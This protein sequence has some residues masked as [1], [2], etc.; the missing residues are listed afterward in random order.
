[1]SSMPRPIRQAAAIPVRAGRVCLVRSRS[2]D[3]WVIP[4]G[5]IEPGHMAG[6]TALRE[7]WEEAG[8]VGRLCPEPVGTY[9]Y[10]KYGRTYQVA[11]YLMHVTRVL[12]D[13]PE[14]SWRTRLWVSAERA[15][16]RLSNRGLRN[17]LWRVA[18][19]ELMGLPAR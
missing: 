16:S 5:R 14:R 2:G 12:G 9:W 6:E 18:A 19:T 7:A 17:L 11:V 15:A 8:L 4:K 1:M 3:H 13:W 10:E